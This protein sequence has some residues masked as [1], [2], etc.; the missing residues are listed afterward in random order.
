MSKAGDELK[1]QLKKAER[2]KHQKKFAAD[3]KLLKI[4]G[5]LQEYSIPGTSRKFKY[6]FADPNIK[7]AV[8]LNGGIWRGKGAHNTPAAL[9][10]DY[11]KI[12]EAQRLG[13]K[14][15]VFTGEQ[16]QAGHAAQY[17][18]RVIRGR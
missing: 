11:E 5:F 13:W 12:N 17:L 9:A 16:V 7:I 2:E 6:D 4:Y 8:E 10:R 14:I 15:F 1:K 3:L 18:E